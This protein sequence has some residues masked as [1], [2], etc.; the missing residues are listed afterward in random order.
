MW[1]SSQVRAA[2]TVAQTA[3]RG[4]GAPPLTYDRAHANGVARPLL[5]AGAHPSYRELERAVRSLK[6]GGSTPTISAVRAAALRMMAMVVAGFAPDAP[7]WW[8]TGHSTAQSLISPHLRLLL[9]V[10][11]SPAAANAA[12]GQGGNPAALQ[13]SLMLQHVVLQ[14]FTER[15]PTP[16]TGAPPPRPSVPAAAPPPLRPLML[17]S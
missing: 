6:R 1:R 3:A 9:A 14:R 12:D 5:Q 11:C 7:P 2:Q 15:Q 10:L 4:A 13:P 17:R 8:S 16:A